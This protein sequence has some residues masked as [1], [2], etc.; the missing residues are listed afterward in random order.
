ML[1]VLLFLFGPAANHTL[2]RN[3]TN[4]ASLL[5]ERSAFTSGSDPHRRLLF[6]ERK[7]HH[8]S[9]DYI[10]CEAKLYDAQKFTELCTEPQ[11]RDRTPP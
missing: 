6:C 2:S 1:F 9:T 8:G 11:D 3:S 7:R 5:H 4:F 10:A